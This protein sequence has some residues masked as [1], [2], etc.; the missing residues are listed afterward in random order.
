MDERRAGN[1]SKSSELARLR[2]RIAELEAA[3]A[4]RIQT[5]KRFHAFVDT[6]NEWIWAIDLDARHTYSNPALRMI[7]GYSPEEFMMASALEYLHEEDRPKVKAFLKEKIVSKDGWSGRVLR[8]R[9]KDGGYR[10]LESTAVPILDEHHNLIGFQGSDR[11]ISE[12]IR[13]EEALKE[14][15]AQFR[16]LVETTTDWIWE[17]DASAIF[18]YCSPTTIEL[19]G[20]EPKELIGRKPFDIMEP[21]EAARLSTLASE[22]MGASRPFTDIENICLHKNGSKVIMES[23]GTPIMDDKGVLRGYRGINRDISRRKQA[24][25]ALRISEERYRM[26]FETMQQGVICHDADGKVTSANPAAERILGLSFDQLIGWSPKDPGPKAV[27]EDGSEFD[28]DQ[29]PAMVALRTRQPVNNVL[30]GFLTR[31][32]QRFR[33]ID[34]GAVPQFTPDETSRSIVYTVF[35]DITERKETERVLQEEFAFRNAIIQY[36]A[37][38]LCVCHEIADFPYVRFTVWNS[39]MIEITGHSMDEINRLGW[40][41]SLYPDPDLQERARER[42]ARMRLDDNLRGEEWE[43]ARSDG[44]KRVVT[45]STSIVRKNGGE[46]HVLALIQD[47]TERKKAEEERLKL[48]AQM[49]RAQKL[50]SLGIL[51]GGI[52][53]DFNNLLTAILGHASLAT[54]ELPPESGVR[55]SLKAIEDASR[56]A[57]DLCRQMLAYAGMGRFVMEPINLSVLIQEF[58]HLL[59]VSISKKVTLRC[60][61]DP[62]LPAIDADA[63]QVRQVIMNLVINASEA[64]G[65][66]EGFVSI[67]TGRI[68]CDEAY[69]RE[70]H[71]A[72][73]PY[74]GSYVFVEVDD[75]GCGMDADTRTRIFDPFFTSKFTGRGL[76][77]AAVLGIVR[78]HKGA[79][80]VESEVGKGT[81]FTVLFPASNAKPKILPANKPELLQGSGLI[82]LVDDEDQVR[83][84]GQAILERC[85]FQAIIARNGLEAID[86][87]RE[88]ASEISCVLLDLTMPQMDGEQTYRELRRI[89]DDVRVILAS[90]Y[91]EQEINRRFRGQGLAGFIAKPFDASELSAMLRRILNPAHAGL[92]S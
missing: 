12:R 27:H 35:T 54:L 8:W 74:P 53:H 50:E 6:T 41:Q 81:R 72:E 46:T 2:A 64:I 3:E 61:L 67:T 83:K 55:P 20:Y 40:Y 38:G 77:L 78:S 88:R 17:M 87:Y 1:L 18:T 63:T 47:L 22:V 66:N 73:T 57:A 84:V 14:S 26:L 92:D 32:E 9:H 79:I 86:I 37:E 82:L 59:Q 65:N 85:G 80:K 13:A 44:T 68:Q 5:E 51:A 34:V 7:L 24:E 25:E 43:I 10:Y 42:M 36:A 69:L 21:D 52:A 16:S 56:R 4:R 60:H 76:G 11:D 62:D 89:R 49:Q 48:E 19:L 29:H 71:A 58:I 45:I 28:R 15:E 31:A 33:W 39:R 23:N 75:T 30:M 91:S 70:S 90:G